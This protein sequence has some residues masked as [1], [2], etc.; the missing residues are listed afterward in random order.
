MQYSD[1]NIP[2]CQNIGECQNVS[3]HEQRHI[4]E[5]DRDQSNSGSNE[6]EQ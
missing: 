1:V 4:P 6:P 3:L 2:W 5:D